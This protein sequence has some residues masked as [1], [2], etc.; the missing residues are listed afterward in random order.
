MTQTVI[1]K[2]FKNASVLLS[3]QVIASMMGLVSISLA[4]RMLGPNKFGIF[5]MIQAYIV[6]VDK[7]LN[8]QSWQAVVKF[9][10]G[11]HREDKK[12]QLQSLVKFCTLLDAI[13]AVAAAVLAALIAVV[14]GRLAG[15]RHE[16]IVAI[17]IFSGH[18]L[19]SIYGTSNGLLRLFGR[20]KYISASKVAVAAIKLALVIAGYFLS[21][22]LIGIVVIWVI[23]SAAESLFFIVA[24]WRQLGRKTG[25]GFLKAEIRKCLR[26]KILWKFV[27]ST[28]VEQS[29][30]LASKELD[31][32]VVGAALGTAA[33]GIYKIAKQFASVLT[34]LTE[35]MCQVIYPELSHLAAEA[36][37]AVMKSF[38]L[39]M[40]AISGV[41]MFTLW[42]FFLV[43]GKWV[44]NIAAG[45][46]FLDSWAVASVLMFAN[47]IWAVAFPL[48]AG[49]LAVGRAEKVMQ[50]Q[51]ISFLIFLPTLY[52]LLVNASLAVAAGAQIL[53]FA[54][55][56]LLM[57]MFF[58]RQIKGIQQ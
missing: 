13:T 6:V 39:K 47:V 35:P 33:S 8:F 45:G 1:K 43:L 49:L 29:I 57:F 48:P 51:I 37:F 10:A 38:M 54:V 34:R 50:V 18:I 42:I 5:A 44:L 24:G 32:L 53:Y 3:G 2:L 55:Y 22:G 23:C 58:S 28:N 52:F 41:V 11:F 36:N 56:A 20:F 16:T 25:T 9:G 15:W 40:S 4:A 14:V 12:P 17:V 30:R 21:A 27:F 46:E 26:D 19:F 31:I 7:L